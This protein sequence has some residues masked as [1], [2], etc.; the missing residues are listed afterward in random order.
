[1]SY[2]QFVEL[3]NTPQ[4]LLLLGSVTFATTLG[5]YWLID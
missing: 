2:Q 5:I 4:V 1:M 3:I